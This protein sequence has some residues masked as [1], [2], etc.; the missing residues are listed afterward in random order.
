MAL[1]DPDLLPVSHP[2]S[3]LNPKS[4]TKKYL[5]EV[6]PNLPWSLEPSFP[7]LVSQDLVFMMSP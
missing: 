4:P 3:S 2:L 7:D 5:F 1:E 6:S